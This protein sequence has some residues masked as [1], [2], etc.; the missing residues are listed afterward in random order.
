MTHFQICPGSIVVR[1]ARLALD[2]LAAETLMET[3]SVIVLH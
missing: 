3:L 1:G 2:Q